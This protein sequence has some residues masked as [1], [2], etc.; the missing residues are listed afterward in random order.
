MKTKML[1][2]SIKLIK[3]KSPALD[4]FPEDLYQTFKELLITYY[5]SSRKKEERT[6]PNFFCEPSIITMPKSDKDS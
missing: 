3:K 1:I 5:F 6:L 4:G 2:Y